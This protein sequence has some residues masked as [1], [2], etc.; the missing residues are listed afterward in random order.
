MVSKNK[1][2]KN[3]TNNKTKTNKQ[4]KSIKT[5]KCKSE[6]A[7]VVLSKVVRLMIVQSNSNKRNIV[8]INS[9][10]HIS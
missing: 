2:N 6:P 1:K 4:T 8:I 10:N 5:A 3:I 7:L 9:R